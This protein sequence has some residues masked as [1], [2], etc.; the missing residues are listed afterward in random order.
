[1]KIVI[2]PAKSLNESQDWPIQKS[3]QPVF[4]EEAAQINRK[5]ARFSKKELADL[6]N[7]SDQLADLNYTRNQD[8]E[9]KPTDRKSVV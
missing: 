4:L 5:L 9:A 1:M 6:M 3:S 2:S 7:I 8:F